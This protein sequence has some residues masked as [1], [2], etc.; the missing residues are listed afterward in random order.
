L[1]KISEAKM[2]TGEQKFKPTFGFVN[3]A[4]PILLCNNLP[5]LAD[6][7]HG[8]MRRLRVVPCDRTFKERETD[9][10]LFN[11]IIKNELAGVLNRALQGWKRLQQRGRFTRS[12]DMKR[13]RQ[14]L[15]IH[16][17]PLKGFIDERCPVEAGS[18]VTLQAFYEAYREWVKDSGY[19][20]AQVKSTVRRN[21]EH[22]GYPVK[23][24]AAGVTIIGIKL[25]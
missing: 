3:R 8:M 22:Q 10:D 24:H 15:L 25:R 17:N 11:R 4:F 14:D 9:R 2:L 16:A 23:R 21:I 19:T 6:L 1:K 18:K 13:A 5:S 7:S 12:N 20:L